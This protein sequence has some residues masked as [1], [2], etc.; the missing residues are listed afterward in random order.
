MHFLGIFEIEESHRHLTIC[1]WHRDEFGIRWLCNKKHCLLPAEWAPHHGTK[2]KGDRGITLIQSQKIH[3]LIP[4][5]LVHVGSREYPS[6][7]AI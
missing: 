2:R 3:T 1:P 5:T 7:E 6:I 4:K